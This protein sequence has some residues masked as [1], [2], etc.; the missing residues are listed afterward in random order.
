MKLTRQEMDLLI[1]CIKAME[2]KAVADDLLGMMTYAAASI[3]DPHVRTREHAMVTGRY[4]ALESQ[5]KVRSERCALLKAKLI[6]AR[7]NADVDDLLGDGG[8]PSRTPKTGH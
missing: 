4:R 1:D 5:H 3:S 7:D 6:Q 2:T 8:K